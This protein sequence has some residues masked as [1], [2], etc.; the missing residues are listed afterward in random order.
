MTEQTSRQRLG[1][2][3]ASVV[4]AALIAFLIAFNSAATFAVAVLAEPQFAALV[5]I[6]L[7]AVVG[8]MSARGEGLPEGTKERILW[9]AAGLVL[10]IAAVLSL[11]PGGIS[12]E[13][14]INLWWVTV[15]LLAALMALIKDDRRIASAYVTALFLIACNVALGFLLVS[16]FSL[17]T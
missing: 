3:A 6:S 7:G 13:L 11:S 16:V 12:G 1:S 15:L 9:T 8:L 4:R 14:V 10:L 2:E 17:R 5:P